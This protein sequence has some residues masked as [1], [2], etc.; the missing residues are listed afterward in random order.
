MAVQKK[1]KKNGQWGGGERESIESFSPMD[2]YLY[3][4]FENAYLFNVGS[5]GEDLCSL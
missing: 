4:S 5:W 1:A 2:T 3:P